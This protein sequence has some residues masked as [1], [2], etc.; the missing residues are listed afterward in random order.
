[1]RQLPPTWS[2][3]SERPRSAKG[4]L[5]SALRG[6][7]P[8]RQWSGPCGLLML[9]LHVSSA[10]GTAEATVASV[11]AWLADTK[12]KTHQLRRPS[13]PV[14]KAAVATGAFGCSD[15][16][17]SGEDELSSTDCGGISSKL[18][19]TPTQTPPVG[20]GTPTWPPSSCH[21]GDQFQPACDA[22]HGLAGNLA[23]FDKP[24][25]AVP[26][27]FLGH[28]TRLAGSPEQSCD[29]GGLLCV[30]EAKP[31]L[32]LPATEPM[33]HPPPECSEHHPQEAC[34]ALFYECVDGETSGVLGDEDGCASEHGSEASNSTSD[35]SS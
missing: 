26:D 30:A 7:G 16:V 6:S 12:G 14:G 18:E 1:L 17:A 8:R 2:R 23:C 33:L 20:L 28:A 9:Q 4:W 11:R 5:P 21:D 25:E 24:Q 27:D 3:R 13:A 22:R 32:A 10:P 19:T 34:G 29:G 35:M 31:V 15:G